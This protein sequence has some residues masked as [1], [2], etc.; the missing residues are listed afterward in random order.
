MLPDR[1]KY[2]QTLAHASSMPLPMLP[3]PCQ[4]SQILPMLPDPLPMLPDPCHYFRIIA[5]ENMV[6]T[7]KFFCKDIWNSRSIKLFCVILKEIMLMI[8]NPLHRMAE[9]LIW[10]RKKERTLRAG[11]VSVFLNFSA[12]AFR[13]LLNLGFFWP[14]Q[15]FCLP[16]KLCCQK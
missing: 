16:Q 9:H 8:K 11:F 14:G 7:V 2:S 3:D 10:A 4:L 13:Q 5:I 12:A 15:P 6:E 1:C